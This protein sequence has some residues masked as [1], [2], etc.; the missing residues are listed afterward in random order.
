MNK[1]LYEVVC[2]KCG[3]VFS[4]FTW[5]DQ[6]EEDIAKAKCTECGSPVRRVWT[7]GMGKFNGTGFTRSNT[8]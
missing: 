7:F 6:I 5:A 4:L 8:Q 1:I 3:E 2:T